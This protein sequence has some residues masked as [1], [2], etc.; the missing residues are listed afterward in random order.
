MELRAGVDE[1]L[2]SD[3]LRCLVIAGNV[4]EQLNTSAMWRSF[5]RLRES[6]HGVSV[7]GFDELFGRAKEM[8]KIL[9]SP[10]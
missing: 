4:G 8:L 6:L 7:I 9:T 5:E 3:T 1:H 10:Q 2:E